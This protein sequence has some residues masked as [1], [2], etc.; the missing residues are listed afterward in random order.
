MTCKE[1]NL[2]DESAARHLHPFPQQEECTIVTVDIIFKNKLQFLSF[3]IFV[4]Y[5]T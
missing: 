1:F 3:F 4:I 5:E 2:F